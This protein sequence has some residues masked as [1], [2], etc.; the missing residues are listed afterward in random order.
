[1]Q[2]AVLAEE[3]ALGFALP[4]SGL[5]AVDQWVREYRFSTERVTDV[6]VAGQQQGK[7]NVAYLKGIARNWHIAGTGPTESSSRQY[8]EPDPRRRASLEE[9]FARLQLDHAELEKRVAK[10]ERLFAL[11][12]AQPRTAGKPDTDPDKYDYVFRR[13]ETETD[14][15]T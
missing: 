13:F 15:G 11:Y 12:L 5:E 8:R 14:P 9:D 7:T 10:L 2:A 1:V 3:E 4:L 6:I